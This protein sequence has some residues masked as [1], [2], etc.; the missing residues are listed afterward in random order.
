MT[1]QTMNRHFSNVDSDDDDQAVLA[2]KNTIREKWFIPLFFG[3]S[4][5][6]KIVLMFLMKTERTKKWGSKKT[7]KIIVLNFHLLILFQL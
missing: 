6:G 1:S 4:F 5:N 3:P 7:F 2:C